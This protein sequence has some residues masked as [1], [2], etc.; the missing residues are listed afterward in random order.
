M[1]TGTSNTVSF[2]WN[3][4]AG[5]ALW[6]IASLIGLY[7]LCI[8]CALLVSLF[9]RTEDQCQSGERI[10]DKLLTNLYDVLS[11]I[12]GTLTTIASLIGSPPDQSSGGPGELDARGPAP[13]PPAPSGHK[14]SGNGQ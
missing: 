2:D 8:V 10:L 7:S 5:F 11:L 9:G 6:L 12:C 14:K 1:S 3:Y 13:S 4:P